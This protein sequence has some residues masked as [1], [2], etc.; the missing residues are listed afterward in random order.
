MESEAKGLISEAAR[1]K[2]EAQAL[3]PHV[4]VDEAQPVATTPTEQS[5]TSAPKKRGR[6][7]KESADAIQS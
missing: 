5:A 7:R 1:M 3:H 6:P 2:K 4:R